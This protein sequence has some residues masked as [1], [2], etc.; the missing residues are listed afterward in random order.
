[1]T[2]EC[3]PR[4]PHKRTKG[5]KDPDPELFIKPCPRDDLARQD[6]LEA[7]EFPE[8]FG[9]PSRQTYRQLVERFL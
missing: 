7:I 9:V 4:N 2:R 8:K 5:R 1:M 6:A 3:D